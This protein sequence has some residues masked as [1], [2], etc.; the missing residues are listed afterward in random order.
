MA[1]NPLSSA[2]SKHIHVRLLFVEELLRS[3]KINFQVVVSDKRHADI[4]KKGLS[5]CETRQI[6]PFALVESAIGSRL[7]MV[8]SIERSHPL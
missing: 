5:Y 7:R 3:R 2:R 4:L 8:L 6:S 1:E